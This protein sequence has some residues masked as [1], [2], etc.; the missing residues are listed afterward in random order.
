MA[1][2]RWLLLSNTMNNPYLLAAK[3]GAC[4]WCLL[5]ALSF[6][7]GFRLGIIEILLLFAI[8][9]I[10]P[11][12]VSLLD[13]NVPNYWE[14]HLAQLM[15]PALSCAAILTTFSFFL[16][17]GIF[18]ARLAAT[19]LAIC[20]AIAV[21]GT[22]Q[23]FA[24]RKSFEQFCFSVGQGYLLV[25]GLWLVA[26]RAG[27][28]PVGFE[29][30]IVLLTAMHFHFAGFAS[31]IVAGLTYRHFRGK[32]GETLVRA[33]SLAVVVGPGL[34]GLAFLAGPKVKL[35]GALLVA[36]GQIGLATAMAR[37]ALQARR[38]A[39]R[40]LLLVAAGSVAAGM[41]FAAVWAIGEY[42]L[43]PF[44]DIRKMAQIHGVLNALGFAGCGLLGWLELARAEA[45]SASDESFAALTYLRRKNAADTQSVHASK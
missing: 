10:V 15:G 34:L 4:V 41:L 5:A 20:S 9:V 31:A 12:G 28:H 11:P 35:I 1:R 8:W 39:G 14:P 7:P 30:P 36:V 26:S 45:Q 42:P 19:W 3:A 27:L 2:P 43:Q 17:R 44:V 22:Y 24:R 37:L 23:F 18:S 25:A 21:S 32:R 33:A 13:S 40:W 6:I 16:D 38:G 29:E